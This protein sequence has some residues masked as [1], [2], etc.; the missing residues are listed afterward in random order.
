MGWSAASVWWIAAGLVVAAELASGTFYL[1]MLALGMAAGALAAHLGLGTVAQ[2]VIAAA[3]GSGATALWHVRRARAP[4]SLPP[5][6]N[7]DVNLD[8]GGRVHVA[9]WSAERSARVRHRGSDWDA[10]LDPTALPASGNHTVIAIDG[11]CLI[12]APAATPAPPAS[13]GGAP[14]PHTRNS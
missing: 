7:P 4:R 11:S 1:L 5:R 12:L 9:A 6:T 3:V 14:N 10:R 13:A 2:L 8:I